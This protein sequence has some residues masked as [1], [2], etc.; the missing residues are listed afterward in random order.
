MIFEAIMS[1]NCIK[2]KYNQPWTKR[3]T[4]SVLST[5]WVTS[6]YIITKLQKNKDK[7]KMPNSRKHTFS[8]NEIFRH[9]PDFFGNSFME[10][11]SHAI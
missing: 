7:K 6:W 8:I 11:Y 2:L 1:E 4:N 5:K 10:I 9:P 3:S